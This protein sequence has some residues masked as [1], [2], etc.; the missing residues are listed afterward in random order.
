[1]ADGIAIWYRWRQANSRS[2]V[3][4][5]TIR[6]R[7]VEKNHSAQTVLQVVALACVVFHR[8]LAEMVD[9]VKVIQLFISSHLISKWCT[10]N[11]APSAPTPA[12]SA[13]PFERVAETTTECDEESKRPNNLEVHHPRSAA[14]LAFRLSR[15]PVRRIICRRRH[16][17]AAA[18]LC[19][20]HKGRHFGASAND[21][22]ITIQ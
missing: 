2:R 14:F 5:R 1:M 17:L 16:S 20:S 15:R 8:G 12:R 4:G 22:N 3:F 7:S 13:P 10:L 6:N 19:C 11:Q 18:S 9:G 21:L